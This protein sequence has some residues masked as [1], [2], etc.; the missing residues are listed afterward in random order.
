ETVKEQVRNFIE[1]YAETHGLPN[2]EKTRIKSNATILLPTEMTYKSVHQ[3]FIAKAEGKSPINYEGLQFQFLEN[4]IDDKDSFMLRLSSLYKEGMKDYLKKEI[5]D[6]SE[7]EVKEIFR[8]QK[9]EPKLQKKI[10][11]IIKDLRLRKANAFAF[12]EVFDKKTFEYNFEVVKKI[13]EI[14]SEYKFRYSERSG[15]LGEFF[16]DLLNTSLK[17][18]FGQFFTPYPLV[19][20]M[21]HALPLKERVSKSI[22]KN[23]LPYFIDYACG[24]GHFLIS[25]MERLQGEID[26]F[27]PNDY[28]MNYRLTKTTK[29][30]LF[31]T[32]DGK[33]EILHADAL[34]KFSCDDYGNRTTTS[35]AIFF[36]KKNG[37]LDLKDL[38]YQCLLINSPKALADYQKVKNVEEEKFLGY[39]FSKSRKKKGISGIHGYEK[40]LMDKYSPLIREMF[41]KDIILNDYKKKEL[42]GKTIE[43]GNIYAFYPR[44]IKRTKK[45]NEFCLNEV[46]E[47]NKH[48]KEEIPKETTNSLGYVEIGKLNEEEINGDFDEKKSW[49][50]AKEG[51]LLFPKLAASN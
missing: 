12:V 20:F 19:D 22:Q 42:E 10:E 49:R 18:E 33:A 21:I 41:L 24:S 43:E 37:S 48:I 51:D 1:N 29:I 31:L 27:N 14:L 50:L 16:E 15:Y 7:E 36:M 28:S 2:T 13:V 9:P 39:K 46:C 44:Y 5:S 45:E 34:N 38:N 25:Y 6:H 26:N 3:N 23:K 47:I 35:P 4:D 17:Q 8:S 30:S 11:E 32:G 40:N